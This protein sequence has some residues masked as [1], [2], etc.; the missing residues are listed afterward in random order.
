MQQL[1]TKFGNSL[2]RND[3]DAAVQ[4]MPS[5]HFIEILV[6]VHETI[7]SAKQLGAI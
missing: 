4:A 2:D 1:D 7:A 6:G 5:Q 3:G